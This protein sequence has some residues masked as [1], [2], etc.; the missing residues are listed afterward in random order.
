MLVCRV[1]YDADGNVNQGSYPAQFDAEN[2]LINVNNGSVATYVYDANGRRIE[3]ITPGGN[4]VHYFYDEEGHVLVEVNQSGAGIKGYAYMAGQHAVEF[5]TQTYFIHTDHLGSTRTVSNYLG[6][7]T[8]KMDYLRYGE[9]IA[10]GTFTTHKFTGYERDAE[11][12]LDYA[13]ARYYAYGAGRFVTPDPTGIFLGNL[14]DPQTLNLYAYVR[15]N[16]TSLTDPTGLDIGCDPDFGCGG[17]DP[18]LGCGGC[19][20]FFGCGGGDGGSEPPP[21]IYTPIPGSSPNPPNGTLTSDDPFSGET[22]GSGIPTLGLPGTLLG[23]TY[24]SGGCG[25]M[26]NSWTAEGGFSIQI[27]VWGLAIQGFYGLAIDQHLHLAIYRGGGGGIGLGAKVSTGI[28]VSASNGN[29]VCPLGGPFTKVRG[30]AGAVAGGT[31][32]V[33]TANGD[34]AG[35]VVVGAV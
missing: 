22:N 25:G 19:D 13:Q 1:L 10:G 4:Q 3:K 33:F 11:A 18:I 12:G 17:C 20:P 7:V 6:G 23:C 24:G 8:D 16:P 32:E 15:N 21:P 27:T 29:S 30:T 26:I 5:T 34:A 2:R 9:Q 31:V 28:S 35:G 14:N